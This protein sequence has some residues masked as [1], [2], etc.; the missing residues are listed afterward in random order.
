MSVGVVPI[1]LA[2]AGNRCQSA[3]AVFPIAIANCSEE[4]LYA[5]NVSVYN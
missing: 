4:V 3:L 1:G 2:A 5:Y